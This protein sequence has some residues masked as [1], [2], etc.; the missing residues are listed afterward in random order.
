M[1]IEKLVADMKQAAVQVL[2][3]DVATIEGFSER[4]VQAIAQQAVLLEQGIANG[5]IRPDLRDYFLENLKDMVRNFI[6]T[7]IGLEIV[8]IEK[9]W[10]ALVGVIWK[11]LS[12]IT[13]ISLPEIGAFK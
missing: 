9:L 5:G 6:R 2:G 1:D 12:A 3:K 4:Q 7:L 13:H 10:N 8:E 11:T